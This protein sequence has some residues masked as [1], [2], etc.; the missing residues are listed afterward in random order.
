MFP[1]RIC[2]ILWVGVMNFKG[3]KTHKSI[4]GGYKETKTKSRDDDEIRLFKIEKE[5]SDTWSQKYPSNFIDYFLDQS[6]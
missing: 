2:I 5:K 1:N 6:Q 3:A 4:F